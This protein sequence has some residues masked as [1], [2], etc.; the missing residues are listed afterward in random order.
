MKAVIKRCSIALIVAL[1]VTLS[2]GTLRTSPEAQQ[3]TASWE[4]CRQSPYY[5]PAGV[6]TVGIGSTGNVQKREYSNEEIA[7]R[8]VND[9]QRAENCI[10]NNFEGETMPQYPFEAMAD[11]ALNL[12]CPNLMW[13]T[14]GQ[15][16]KQRTTIW[17]HAQAHEWPQMCARLTDFVN[18]AGKRSTGLVNRRTDFKAWCLRGLEKDK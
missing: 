3:K 13:F 6:L 16:R 9:M 8:W 4:D 12:G 10:N 18:S 1:G 15:G 5:C 14:N 11:A 17:K 7:R 2:P